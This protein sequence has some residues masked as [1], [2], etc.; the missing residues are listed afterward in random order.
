[1]YCPNI[2]QSRSCMCGILAKCTTHIK[3]ILILVS[4]YQILFL[5]NLLYIVGIKQITSKNIF[6]I[7]SYMFKIVYS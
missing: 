4:T 6:V 2:E 1:M 3:L 5:E 7:Y